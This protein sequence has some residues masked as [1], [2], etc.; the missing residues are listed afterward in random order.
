MGTAS[1]PPVDL[2]HQEAAAISP[3]DLPADPRW[4][5]IEQLADS[6][7]FRKSSRLPALLRYLARCTLTGDRGGLTEQT[8]GKAVFGKRLDYTPAEDSSVRVYVRQLRLRLHEYYQT[9][10]EALLY[11]VLLPKGGYALTFTPSQSAVTNAPEPAM[12]TPAAPAA[13]SGVQWILVAAMSAVALICA[14]GWLNA[15]RT[16]HQPPWPLNQVVSANARTTVVLADA[17]Y[18][19]RKLGD[20]E[21]PLDQYIDRSYTKNIEPEHASE[22]ELSLIRY[23]KVAR[24]TSMADAHAAAEL[25]AITAPYSDNLVI[26]SAKDLNANDLTHGDFVFVGSNSSNPWVKLFDSRLNFEFVEEFPRGLRYI[27]NRKPQTGESERYNVSGSTGSSGWDYATLS[28]LPAG[29]GAGKVF[30]IQGLRMEGTEAAL[31]L[32]ADP[33]EREKMQ[34]RIASAN[35]NK[36]PEYFEVLLRAQSI[37]GSPLSLE[38]LAV[39]AWSGRSSF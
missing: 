33:Q 9:H 2:S 8:I 10:S 7:A 30:L 22:G 3:F 1:A 19:L 11:T 31:Q 36:V 4:Q 14:V 6:E 25:T 13:R 12:T 20:R 16:R 37:A 39:R 26:K 27:R 15:V 24:L 21:V 35:Q 18:A 5:V 28:L 38:L 23:L 29:N 17:G 34:D 32:L